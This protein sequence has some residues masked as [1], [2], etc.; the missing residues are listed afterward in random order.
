MCTLC[1]MNRLTR[2]LETE[3]DNGRQDKGNPKY[4]IERQ[5]II[6]EKNSDD[7]R[8]DRFNHGHNGRSG[9]RS[10]SQTDDVDDE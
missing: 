9:R 3:Q 6:Q 4:L 10:V 5:H 8:S 7:S 1:L 2:F